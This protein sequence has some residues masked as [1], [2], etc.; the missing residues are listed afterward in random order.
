MELGIEKC[1][2][3]IRKSGKQHMMEEMEQQNQEKLECL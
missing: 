2:M 3:L 1:A